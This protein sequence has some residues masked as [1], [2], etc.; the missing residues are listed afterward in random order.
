MKRRSA[1]LCNAGQPQPAW[2]A[3]RALIA[4][5]IHAPADA[6]KEAKSTVRPPSAERE[7]EKYGRNRRRA[8]FVRNREGRG[9][10]KM[11]AKQEKR[12]KKQERHAMFCGLKS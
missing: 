12:L 9:N 4:S 2:G 6:G 10:G 7:T 5:G 11:R 8:G 3:S 1:P